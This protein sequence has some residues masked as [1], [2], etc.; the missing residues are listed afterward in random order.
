MPNALTNKSDGYEYEVECVPLYTEHGKTRFFGTRRKDTGEIFATVTSAYEV[1]QN[2][3]LV[4]AAEAAF[5]AKGLSGWRRKAVVARG[6]ARC[7]VV[8]DFPCVGGKIA[9]QDVTFRLIIQNSFD[10]TVRAS[11]TIGLFRLICSNGMAVP[12]NT[13]GMTKRHVGSIEMDFVARTVEQA[14]RLFFDSLPM[15]QMMTGIKVT[16]LEGLR[17]INSLIREGVFTMKDGDAVSAIW[18]APSHEED[19]ARTLWNLYNAVTQHLTHAQVGNAVAAR[20]EESEKCSLRI[21]KAFMVAA[22]I[23]GIE[24]LLKA[25]RSN[26]TPADSAKSERMTDADRKPSATSNVENIP[27]P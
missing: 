8:Y 2:R 24:V 15:F 21:S 11:F 3:E 19:C 27:A 7:Y 16:Q 10:G 6:G 4:Q 25:D 12:A 17:I 5:K 13:I 14:L 9:G 22:Q 26:S 23:G 18:M 20:F 1:L